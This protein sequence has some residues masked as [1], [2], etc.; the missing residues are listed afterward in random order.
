MKY[1]D[2]G[3][4]IVMLFGVNIAKNPT[5]VDDT[6]KD[7]SS[8]ENINYIPHDK[9]NITHNNKDISIFEHE[10]KNEKENENNERS[11]FNIGQ[12]SKHEKM[13]S[14]MFVNILYRLLAN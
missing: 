14:G 11:E 9:I 2:N 12:N 1:D 8:M 13:K 5:K 6:P 10:N 7:S 3:E 4:R